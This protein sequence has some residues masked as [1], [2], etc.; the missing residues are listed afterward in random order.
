MS[1]FDSIK[2]RLSYVSRFMGLS[3]KEIDLMLS[4]KRIKKAV[5]NL[6]GKECEALRI[7][8]N[9]SLGPG[10]GGIRFHPGVCEDQVKSLAFWMSLK[11]SLMGL[12]YGGGKGG[13]R[14]NPKELKNGEME[15]VSR[16]YIKE[17]H[18][19]LGENV[20]VPAPD[21]YTNPK[22]MGWMLDEYEKIKG[23]HEPGMITGKPLE[24]QGL[25][26]RGD[27]T[28]KGGF[29][30]LKELLD[31]VKRKDVRIAIQ[32]FGNA[33][34]NIASMLYNKGFKVVAISDS[35][36]GILDEAGLD[37]Q[38]VKK[39]KEE[40]RTVVEH[41]NCK[42]ITNKELLELDID[43]LILA[44]MENQI[45]G[46]NA[47]RIRAKYILELANGPV[48]TDAD[49]ILYKKGIIAIPDILANAGGV[50][51]SYFE[52]CQNKVGNIFEDDYLEKKLYT[53]MKTAFH[54]VYGLFEEHKELDMRSAAYVIAIKRILSAERARGN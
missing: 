5:I 2:K 13:V 9:D 22:V 19:V 11:N 47:D 7:V 3:Q 21:V 50:V 42:K 46:G 8:H 10:K 43:V 39:T 38:K 1:T 25:A 37:I 33:G 45:T 51:V 4:F 54:K 12:P 26:L 30:V 44:A 40:K 31:K 18:E 20:D 52:W 6:N 14:I 35:K 28:A 23:R 36:G 24:L 48:T 15:K 16:A 34:M 41:E 27:A 17:M 53:I 29:I 49:A 32:G